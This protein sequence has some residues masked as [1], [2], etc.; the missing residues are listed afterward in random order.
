M[1][2][3]REE[4]T[5][6]QVESLATGYPNLP[7]DQIHAGHQLGHRMLDLDPCIHLEKVEMARV[8]EQKLD[9]ARVGVGDAPR[10]RDGCRGKGLA[11][12]RRHGR[13]FF[14]DLLMTSLD[15]ALPLD[16]R[17]HRALFVPEHLNLDVP[18]VCQPALKV[19]RGLTERGTGFRPHREEGTG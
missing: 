14:E 9:R 3:R 19:D 1:T 6:V 4:S 17:Q 10:D 2:V 12:R 18:R 8:V 11:Q 13:C 7:L 16:E 5:W 15:R